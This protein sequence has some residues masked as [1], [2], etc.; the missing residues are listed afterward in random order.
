MKI[1][2][3][4]KENQNNEVLKN[5]IRAQIISCFHLELMS[6]ETALALSDAMI[7]TGVEIRNYLRLQGQC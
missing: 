3:N 5:L 6:L 7:E 1:E 2:N 4:S